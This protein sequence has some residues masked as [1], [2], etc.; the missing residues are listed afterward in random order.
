MTRVVEIFKNIL[1]FLQS[2][3]DA[4]KVAF[5]SLIF[6][7][8]FAFL[9]YRSQ[10][11]QNKESE[12]KETKQI[13]F[14]KSAQTKLEEFQ[15]FQ[16]KF[17]QYQQKINE[18]QFSIENRSNLMPYFHLN[19]TKSKTYRNENNK[20][21]IEIYLTNVGQ[22]TATNIKTCPMKNEST[23]TDIYLKQDPFLG[24]ETH[25]IYDYF[26]ENFAIPNESIKFEIAELEPNT[27]QTYFLRFKLKFSDAIGR[28]YE[29]EFR[30][31]YDKCLVNGINQ[32]S[33]SDSPKLIKDIN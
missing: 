33:A 12:M 2:L 30:F 22:G 32:N 3:F 20:L 15:N 10:R 18:L 27:Q 23:G 26:N 11:K 14:Q 8:L 17:S 16:A 6:T 7:L 9:G 13:A 28:E 19:R 31:G 25:R 21:I 5:V 1:N 29:Q 24:K 4:D